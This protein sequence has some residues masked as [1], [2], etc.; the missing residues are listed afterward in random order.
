MN[1]FSKLAGVLIVFSTLV[2]SCKEEGIQKPEENR[3]T[4]VVVAEDL[5]EPMQFEL[6]EDGRVLVAERKGTIKLY[7]P[8]TEQVKVIA[9]IPVSTGYYSETGEVL[10]TSGED[11]LQGI[12]VD[13]NYQQNHWVYVYYSPKGGESRSLLSRFEWR[14]DSILTQTEKVLLEI[15]NQRISCC[16]LG[17]GMIFDADGNLLLSTGDNTPNDDDGYSPLDER[18]GRSRQDAQ[19]SS[20]NTND[21]RGKI[22][23]IHP[24]PDG[25][26]SIP[27]GNLFPEGMSNGSDR[28]SQPDRTRPEIYT[29]GNRNP[30]RLSLDSETGWLYWGEVGPYGTIDSVGRG[31]KSYDEFNQARE[32]GNFGWPYFVADN[33]AYWEYDYAT[34]ESGE[35]FDP[36]APVNNSP[37]NTGLTHLPP[38][39]PAFIWYPQ[40]ESEE[41]PLLGNG[42]NSAV[43]GPIYRRADLSNPKRPFPE[44]YEGKWFITDW[45]RGWIMVVTMD[46]DGNFQSL[47][48]FLPDLKLSGPIDMGFGSEGDLYILEYGRGTYKRNNDARLVRIEYN[49]GNRAPQVQATA[50][51]T[52]G[53]VP[54]QVQL[55]AAGTQD[56]D[57]DDLTYQWEILSTNRPS[58]VYHEPNP[59]V[60]I[61]ESGVF[62]AVLTVT[63]EHGAKSSQT[64]EIVVGNEAPEV[65]FNFHGANRSFFFPDDT[66]HYSV[67]VQDKEDGSLRNH[68]ID[69]TQVAVSI[70]YVSEEHSIADVV[71]T[72]VSA[73]ASESLSDVLAHQLINN[74]DCRACHLEDSSSLGPGYQEIAEKYRSDE[75]AYDRLIQKI[76]SGGSGVWGEEAMPP[77]PSLSE[78][79]AGIIVSYILSK[80]TQDDKQP[81]SVSG[82]FP[83]IVPEG[84]S[85]QGH[86]IFRASYTDQGHEAVASQ[87][88]ITTVALR[89]PTVP[90]VRFDG[91]QDMEIVHRIS[92]DQSTAI[93]KASGAYLT[94][95]DVDLTG[96]KSAEF[97]IPTDQS[98]SNFTGWTIEI[99]IDSVSGKLIGKIPV[100]QLVQKVGGLR[101]LSAKLSPINGHHDLY[102]IFRYENREAVNKM[103]IRTVHIEKD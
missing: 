15:S 74:S 80:E 30:W 90:V 9:D 101:T 2:V 89:N 1:C 35:P 77:H 69:S 68:Q 66:L 60:T 83:M 3:F 62:Q 99:R 75:T 43:G 45:T 47:E 51:K 100:D 6:L 5:N 103:Q 16:H 98:S 48:P 50:D 37:H 19:R 17:G 88:G 11:G 14:G 84:K 36:A 41:F 18:P 24:E 46:K 67:S 44:Y 34:K 72:L 58:E 87:T 7:D 31:P 79:E 12:V 57:Q 61:I 56:Y 76:I 73:K 85:D 71:A 54:L 64:V 13:P 102:F 29:M 26:Y 39:Q 8:D 21:L 55:S 81:Y 86:F 22:L 52:T 94:L 40:I 96:I 63:D 23:R 4:L 10:A 82:T 20:S 65:S 95:Q 38:A 92:V 28:R 78:S 91:F 33:K 59:S 53:A 93:P 42:S 49:G 27:E 70:D 32:A 97:E 25:G